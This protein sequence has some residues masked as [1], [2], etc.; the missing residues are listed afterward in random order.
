[1]FLKNTTLNIATL[2][3]LADYDCDKNIKEISKKVS[4]R[5]K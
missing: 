4:G 2:Y 5:L 3:P 1:M